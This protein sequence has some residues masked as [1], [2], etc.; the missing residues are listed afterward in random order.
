MRG[1]DDLVDQIRKRMTKSYTRALLR[2]RRW[3]T[4]RAD[5]NPRYTST[6]GTMF[7]H[8]VAASSFSAHRCSSPRIAC[9][10]HLMHRLELLDTVYEAGTLKSR[11][12]HCLALLLPCPKSLMLV[13]TT[14]FAL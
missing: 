1:R 8:P 12:R 2:D 4:P 3:H 5:L 7:P 10:L 14:V 11:N 13:L 6:H 9:V